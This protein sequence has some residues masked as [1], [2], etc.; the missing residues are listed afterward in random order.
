MHTSEESAPHVLC[1]LCNSSVL[2]AKLC[3][4]HDTNYPK[5]KDKD[6]GFLLNLIEMTNNMQLCRTIYYS[7]VL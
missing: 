7:F 4:Q 6:I 3:K 1:V 2:P 5:Y